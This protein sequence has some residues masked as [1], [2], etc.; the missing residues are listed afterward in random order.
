[1]ALCDGTWCGASH[2]E[3]NIEILEK[4]FRYGDGVF[5]EK[6]AHEDIKYFDGIGVNDGTAQYLFNGAFGLTVEDHILDTYKFIA[7]RYNAHYASGRTGEVWLF[8]LSRGAYTVRCVAGIIHNFGIL[9]D[10]TEENCRAVY[11]LYR[12]P[13]AQYEPSSAFSKAFRKKSS[14]NHA[15]P[16][17]FMGL[18]D[19]VGALGIPNFVDGDHFGYGLYDTVVGDS[20]EYVCQATSIHDRLSA[21][22]PCSISRSATGKHRAGASGISSALAQEPVPTIEECL[23]PGCHYDLGRQEFVPW[24]KGR[25][26]V[27]DSVTNTIDFA[28]ATLEYFVG[29]P[30]PLVATRIKPDHFFAD[31]TLNYILNRCC[32][33]GVDPI[34]VEK[35]FDEHAMELDSSVPLIS[36]ITRSK[37]SGNP[38]F[39][40]GDVYHLVPI[41]T[42][43]KERA[44][45]VRKPSQ[46][47]GLDSYGNVVE[48]TEQYKD[49]SGN[50]VDL[51]AHLDEVPNAHKSKALEKYHAITGL[52]DEYKDPDVSHANFKYMIR[53]GE[54]FNYNYKSFKRS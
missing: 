30:G 7:E 41:P 10:P 18:F 22:Q 12:N 8:G 1:M 47:R 21:F 35:Y 39:G 11:E 15:K 49:K 26:L 38:A 13:D 28:L 4:M 37:Q 23:L 43:L 34:K 51:V 50:V 3:S 6:V 25:G 29:R 46:A 44:L 14:H 9:K 36:R 42:F 16:I 33:V 52:I 17:K 31:H 19:T 54:V 27:L 5:P 48:L 40:T 53:G 20:V 32:Q 2:T 24:R 45:P